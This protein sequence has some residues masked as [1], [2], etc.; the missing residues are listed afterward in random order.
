VSDLADLVITGADVFT[1]D[2]ARPWASGVAI[3]GDRIVAVAGRRDGPQDDLRD[4]IGPATERLE[5]AG[6]VV[7]PGFQDAHVHPAF[8]G[9]NLLR[10]HLDDLDSRAAVLD[11]IGR[12]A[13]EHPSEPWILGGG[14]AMRLFREGTPT[15]ADLDAV[16]SDRPVFLMNRDVHTAWTNSRALEI[17]GIDRAT[18]DPWDGRIERDP[19]SGQPTGALHEGA[20]Y[21]FWE[22]VV[23]STTPDEWRA[24][25]LAAQRHLHG[26]GITGWQDAWVRP[27]LLRA[28]RDLDDAGEL[29]ARVVAAL[30]WD[31]HLGVEQVDDFV[32]QRAWGEGGMVQAGTVK[33]M[34][35]GVAETY[36]CAMLESY[37]GRDGKPTGN[38]GLAYLEGEPLKEAVTRLDAAG[39]QVHMHAIG[40]RAVRGSLDAVEAARRLN[41]AHDLRHHIAH[42]Q[43]VSSDDVPRFARLG[44]VAN[45]Q[46]LWA[47]HDAQVDE[48]TLPQVGGERAARMYPFGDLWR[49]GASLAM[50]SDWGVSSPDPLLQMEVAVTRTDPDDR[51]GDPL[52]PEQALDLS[53]A[54]AA[55]T[56]GSAWVNH[57]EDAGSIEPGKRADLAILDRNPF[58]RDAGPVGET[59]VQMTIA[60]GRV[61]F[62]GG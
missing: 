43:F 37:L 10:V 15:A 17:G 41:G 59:R 14:W 24:A 25:I 19:V 51:A 4:L 60:A 18:P 53:T 35:D 13:R 8:A 57:D 22:H 21:D 1:I 36:T 16:V 9:R 47:C 3:R 27:D 54:M 11:R 5:L 20:A 46:A 6:G 33:I 49:S 39:F 58:A 52:L 56:R 30:W 55:F 12:Y 32:E 28:Y 29:T 45:L 61:V 42:L 50:G 31:R 40:D 38:R 44:V 7:V 62:D 48:L 34:T 2:P 23:P 26:V